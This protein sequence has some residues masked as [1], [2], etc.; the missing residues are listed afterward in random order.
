MAM[1]RIRNPSVVMEIVIPTKMEW[2]RIP[3]SRRV[4]FSERR[5]NVA[6]SI[7]GRDSSSSKKDCGAG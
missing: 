3:P 4:M 1:R 6:G 2:K 5:L 7:A